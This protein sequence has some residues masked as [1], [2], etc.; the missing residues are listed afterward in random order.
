MEVPHFIFWEVLKVVSLIFLTLLGAKIIIVMRFSRQRKRAQIAIKAALLLALLAIAA[1]GA[2]TLGYDTA[3][4]LYYLTAFKNLQRGNVR[5]AYANSLR[6]VRLRPGELRYWQLLDRTKIEGH[7]FA[8]ALQDEPFLKSL[9]HGRLDLSDEAR[10]ATCR[11][12][13]GQY[14]QVILTTRQM[15][16]QNRFYPVAYLIQGMSYIAL[17]QYPQAENT[18]MSMLDLFPSDANGVAELAHA[19]Y[20]AGDA[21]R[22]IAVLNMTRKYAFPPQARQR[23]EELKALY[24]Q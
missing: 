7:Q 20:L 12:F 10:F 14:H 13:L 15:I 23:F 22:A 17:K 3:G 16:Q 2:R 24:A 1:V 8:S 9:C 4:E 11:Y 5:L 19:Y 6:A 18:L 21:L